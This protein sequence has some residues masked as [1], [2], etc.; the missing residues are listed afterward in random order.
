MKKA[1]EN[2]DYGYGW[3]LDQFPKE[4]GTS[5][6]EA[7]SGMDGYDFG[8]WE[9]PFYPGLT[10]I[11]LGGPEDGPVSEEFVDEEYVEGDIT[12]PLNL[13]PKSFVNI[14]NVISN[15]GE[16]SDTID[17]QVADNIDRALLPGGRVRLLDPIELLHPILSYLK[18]LGYTK[19]W[20]N[21]NTELDYNNINFEKLNFGEED[22]EIY[23]IILQKP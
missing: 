5:Y 15:F 23:E 18:S 6:A 3:R 12:T 22:I 10:I 11:D 13:E 19:V 7:L 8:G 9:G 17:R 1:Q 20:S 21:A 16:R 14:S 2:T 4:Y